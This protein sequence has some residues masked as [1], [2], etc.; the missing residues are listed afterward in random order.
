MS[1]DF[2]L[3]IPQEDGR[4]LWQASLERACTL[5]GQAIPGAH[6]L[7]QIPWRDAVGFG[8]ALGAATTEAAVIQSIRD[9]PEAAST[10]LLY[11]IRLDG[12]FEQYPDQ[13]YKMSVSNRGHE[14]APFHFLASSTQDTM[15]REIEKNESTP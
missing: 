8:D 14:L 3:E 12:H 15:Q 1:L 11:A 7:P 10:F 4:K 6:Q 2:Y 13:F 9:N 5:Y